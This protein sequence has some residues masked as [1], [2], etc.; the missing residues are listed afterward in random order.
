MRNINIKL[1][2]SERSEET[3]KKAAVLWF[4]SEVPGSGD[5]AYHQLMRHE[6]AEFPEGFIPWQP[7]EDHHCGQIQEWVDEF[8]DL[9]TRTAEESLKYA[10]VTTHA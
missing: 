8:I 4:F 2:V 5:L 6:G 3:I 10:E 9:M 7:F 1:K